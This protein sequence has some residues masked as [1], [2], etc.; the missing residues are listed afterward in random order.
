MC[1][2]YAFLMFNFPNSCSWPP[3]VEAGGLWWSEFDL[4]LVIMV[5]AF[6]L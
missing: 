5:E 3:Q 4:A 2:N 6:K 1:P